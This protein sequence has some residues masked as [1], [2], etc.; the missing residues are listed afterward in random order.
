MY[1]DGHTATC[2]RLRIVSKLMR[3]FRS[4][5]VQYAAD[6]TRSPA[7]LVIRLLGCPAQVEAARDIFSAR[8][9]VSY[10]GKLYVSR[11]REKVVAMLEVDVAQ[12]GRRKC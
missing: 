3:S 1:G 8:T 4:L 9:D 10:Q 5:S 11:V 2:Q 12:F 7:S 6:V